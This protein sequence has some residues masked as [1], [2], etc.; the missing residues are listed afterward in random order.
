[1]PTVIQTVAGAGHFTGLAGAGL[2]E[3]ASFLP[4]LADEDDD[5][6]ILTGVALSN[7]NGEVLD[8]NCFLRPF[9]DTNTTS[10]RKVI[11]RPTTAQGGFNNDGCRDFIDRQIFG[12]V[13]DIRPWSL[14]LITAG[15][16]TV[17]ASLV[18][19]FTLGSYA[20]G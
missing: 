12:A 17:D 20:K 5:R 14:V 3:F 7:N 8:I 10:R 15:T 4:G 9:A 18:V 2:I 1:M 19:S 11:L 6:P 16:K 13:A